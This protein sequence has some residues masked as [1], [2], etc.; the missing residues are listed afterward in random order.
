MLH[1]RAR[2]IHIHGTTHIHVRVPA[3]HVP[4]CLPVCS[5]TIANGSVILEH[6]EMGASIMEMAQ[7]ARDLAREVRCPWVRGVLKRSVWIGCPI[8]GSAATDV[9]PDRFHSSERGWRGGY[10]LICDGHNRVLGSRALIHE[11]RDHDNVVIAA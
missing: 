11:L 7:H 6:I 5:D 8:G 1:A 10:V 4:W 9:Q 2:A 3:I